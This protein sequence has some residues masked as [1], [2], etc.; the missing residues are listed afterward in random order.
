MVLAVNTVA[1]IAI[2]LSAGPALVLRAFWRERKTRRRLSEVQAAHAAL[3]AS[4]AD[5]RQLAEFK[6][7]LFENAPLSMIATNRDGVI[8]AMNAAADRLSGYSRCELVGLASITILYDEK[9]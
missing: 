7:S 5:Y 3:A 4:Q 1:G 6:D 8:T 2:L 9:E